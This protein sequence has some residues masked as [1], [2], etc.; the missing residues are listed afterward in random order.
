VLDELNVKRLRLVAEPGDLVR[1]QVRPKLHL[2]G[3]RYGRRLPAVQA[4]LAE[5]DGRRLARLKAAGEPVTVA[6]QGLE[7]EVLADEYE[8]ATVDKEGYAVAE[9]QG[10][11]V[12]L[13]RRLTPELV[14]EGLARELVHKLQSMR[15]AAGFRIEDRIITTYQPGA[16]AGPLDEVFAAFGEHIKQETLSLELRL[17]EPPAG[18][19]VERAAVDGYTVTLGVVRAEASARAHHGPA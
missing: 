13:D 7:V 8:V 4:A 17:G 16:A 3:P 14:R 18:A 9:E 1:Y 5:L 6:V 12:A 15:K 2:L 19:Y 11:L 10:Y